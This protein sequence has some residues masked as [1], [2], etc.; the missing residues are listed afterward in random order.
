[1]PKIVDWNRWRKLYVQSPQQITLRALS[2]YEDAP[3][4]IALR[5]RSAKESWNEQRDQ[6]K[7]NSVLLAGLTPEVQAVKREVERI[8]DASET[9]KRH[10]NAAKFIG[11]KAL[12]AIQK[13]AVDDIGIKDAV[14]M[15]RLAVEVEQAIYRIVADGDLDSENVEI[16]DYAQLSDDELRQI[17]AG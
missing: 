5:H 1:M 15:L 2:E 11:Q 10:S 12:A 7:N 4:Y 14:S 3:S 8:I 16:T 9:L 13:T 6:Y 17:A